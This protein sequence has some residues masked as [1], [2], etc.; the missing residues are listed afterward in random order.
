METHSSASLLSKYKSVPASEP[1]PDRSRVA[2]FNANFVGPAKRIQLTLHTDY[3]YQSVRII[4]NFLAY[5]QIRK[6][7][8]ERAKRVLGHHQQYKNRGFILLGGSC[9]NNNVSFRGLGYTKAQDAKTNKC[10]V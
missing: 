8:A 3:I 2:L 6:R 5:I 4:T 1:R 9:W 10:I 7:Q